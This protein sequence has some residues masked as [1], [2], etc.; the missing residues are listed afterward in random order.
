MSSLTFFKRGSSGRKGMDRFSHLF[1][2]GTRSPRSGRA[3][4][5]MGGLSDCP[6]SHIRKLA[7]QSTKASIYVL[8]FPFPPAPQNRFKVEGGL[9]VGFPIVLPC[10]LVGSSVHITKTVSLGVRYQARQP[11]PPFYQQA[12]GVDQS[13][14]TAGYLGPDESPRRRFR[15]ESWKIRSS[16]SVRNCIVT[17]KSRSKIVKILSPWCYHLTG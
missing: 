16:M 7:H 3:V 2:I 12:D 8:V 1:F 5:S 9:W 4:R 15:Q 17:A 10:S 13:L 11:K 14:L 6:Y